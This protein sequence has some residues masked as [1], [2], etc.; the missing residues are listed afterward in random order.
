MFHDYFSKQCTT[1]DN[2]SAI[3]ANTCFVTEERLSTFE[4]SPGD[5][6]K[7][8]RLLDPNKAHGQDEIS[9]LMIKLC[10]S[11]VSKPLAILFRNCLESECCEVILLIP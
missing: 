6:V 5:V 2:N 4:I 1:I 9:I 8:I 10:A 11:S 3:P 7:I